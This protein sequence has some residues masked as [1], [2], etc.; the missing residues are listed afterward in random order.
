MKKYFIHQPLFRLLAPSI[1][2]VLV[3]LLILLLNND[4]KQATQLFTTEEVY[5]CIGLSYLS[6]E[7]VRLLIIVMEK[8]SDRI[9]MLIA[10][11]L[12]ITSLISVAVVLLALSLY[13]KY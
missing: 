13:F 10:F 8:F 2:G 4:V 1:Y 3:Y 5:V 9:R 11:Q 7:S 12:L 6:I